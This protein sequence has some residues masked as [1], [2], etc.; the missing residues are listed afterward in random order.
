MSRY[1]SN[2]QSR[3]NYAKPRIESSELAQERL[4]GGLTYPSFLWTGRILERLQAVDCMTVGIIL[5]YFLF[6]KLRLWGFELAVGR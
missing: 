4:E 6:G 1:I 3:R 5:R 2:W